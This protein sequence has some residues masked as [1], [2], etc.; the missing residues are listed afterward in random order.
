MPWLGGKFGIY[1][2]AGWSVTEATA[3]KVKD[4]DVEAGGVALALFLIILQCELGE[5]LQ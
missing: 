2:G 5:G 3:R 1:S 4:G